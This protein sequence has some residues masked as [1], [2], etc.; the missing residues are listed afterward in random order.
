MN[1]CNL[2]TD[3]PWSRDRLGMIDQD[4]TATGKWFNYCMLTTFYR[5]GG[6]SDS[7]REKRLARGKHWDCSYVF[8]VVYVLIL[9]MGTRLSAPEP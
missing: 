4:M 3:L 6:H 9:S 8:A 7:R 2:E 5:L 1:D